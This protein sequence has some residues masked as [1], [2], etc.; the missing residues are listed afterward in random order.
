MLAEISLSASSLSILRWPARYSRRASSRGN[1]GT[2]GKPGVFPTE[3]PDAVGEVAG[4][5]PKEAGQRGILPLQ[6]SPPGKPP[7]SGPGDCSFAGISKMP[8][9]PPGRYP[10]RGC[11]FERTP[12]P[13]GGCKP[14]GG[15]PA[16]PP[17]NGGSHDKRT[18]P[19]G[20]T[21]SC[22]PRGRHRG[23]PIHRGKA[24]VSRRKTPGRRTHGHKGPG[25]P[26]KSRDGRR[27]S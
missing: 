19:L 27:P 17:R 26:R 16:W 6:Q 11:E 14:Y 25:N 22:T 23:I 9:N 7:G 12:W 2:T 3:I 18:A 5:F 13:L 24:A 4:F 8:G 1:G 15:L 21:V 20:E 10:T